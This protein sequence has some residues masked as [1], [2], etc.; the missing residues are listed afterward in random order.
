M[1]LP[2]QTNTTSS[3]YDEFTQNLVLSI[4]GVSIDE[5]KQDK[6]EEMV[7]QCQAIYKNYMQK[8]FSENFDE[9]DVTRLKSVSSNPSIL[10]KFPD[11]AT[12]FEQAYQSFLSQLEVSWD[13]QP[14][15]A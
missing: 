8:Y 1:A 4:L 5:I 11:F 7:I 13:K 10:E 12:K 14:I 6:V 3:Q 2:N 9:A 15:Q